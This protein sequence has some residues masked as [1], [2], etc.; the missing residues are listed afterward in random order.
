MTSRSGQYVIP[1]MHAIEGAGFHVRRPFPTPDLPMVDPFLLLDHMGPQDHAP[2]EAEGAPDHPHRGFETVS[3][4]LEGAFEHKDS[5]GNSGRIGPGAVQWMT[6]GAGVVHSEM[7]ATEIR[8]DGGRLHGFQVWVNLPA[9]AKMIP[10]RYQD[11]LAADVPEVELDGGRVTV[12][13]IAG[14]L[15]GASAAARTHTP[16][17]YWHLRL[18]PGGRFVGPV[19]EAWNAMAY[20]VDGA[21]LAGGAAA[22]EGHLVLFAPDGDEVVVVAG[23]APADVLLLAGEPIREPVARY[24]PFV[25]NTREEILAAFEDYQAGRMGRITV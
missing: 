7:P 4:I 5:V 16:I 13:V 14:D 1:A 6:A 15:A 21:V 9:A 23:D 25:M 17:A 12:R 18:A 11:V 10:P 22:A 8:T 20:V 24:G 3:Y 2:G 19:P